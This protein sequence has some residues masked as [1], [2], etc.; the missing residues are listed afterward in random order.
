MEEGSGVGMWGRWEVEGKGE[1][2][3][4]PD[5]FAIVKG[6]KGEHLE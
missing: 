3:K 5:Y 4:T 6:L 1:L 2:C